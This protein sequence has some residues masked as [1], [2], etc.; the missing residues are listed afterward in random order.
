MKP[1]LINKINAINKISKGNQT[2]IRDRLN[3]ALSNEKN[4]K[5]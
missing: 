4:L 1:S 3:Q 5:F 2:I